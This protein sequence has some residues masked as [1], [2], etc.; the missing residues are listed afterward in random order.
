LQF[1]SHGGTQ[2]AKMHFAFG[3]KKIQKEA[4]HRDR[5]STNLPFGADNLKLNM[6][7]FQII[8]ICCGRK[9]QSRDGIFIPANFR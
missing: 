1:S 6:V 4:L 2:T 8:S 5:E 7:Q 9:K 3:V